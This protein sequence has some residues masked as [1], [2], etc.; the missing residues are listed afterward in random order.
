MN[1]HQ[2]HLAPSDLTDGQLEGIR[3]VDRICS[4][5]TQRLAL[6]NDI[7][8][9]C[10]TLKKA[11]YADA[12]RYR[13]H[14]AVQRASTSTGR[15]SAGEKVEFRDDYFDTMPGVEIYKPIH[16]LLE[17]SSNIDLE[18]VIEEWNPPIP[19]NPFLEQ[20]RIADA[21]FGPDAEPLDGERAP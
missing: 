20:G 10:G 13:A 16:Q 12:D 14:K 9:L 1:R 5:R 15:L 7:R 17:K 11:E 6:K 4:P 8:T 3:N 19:E 2:D 21:F 18:D